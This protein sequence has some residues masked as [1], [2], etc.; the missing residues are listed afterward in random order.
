M[1]LYFHGVQKYEAWERQLGNGLTDEILQNEHVEFLKLFI[2]SITCR[3]KLE[4]QSRAE[5]VGES[6]GGEY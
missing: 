2:I 4:Y 6:H 5:H 3:S 1:N